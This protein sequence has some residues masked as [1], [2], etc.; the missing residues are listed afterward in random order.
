M[1]SLAGWCNLVSRFMTYQ[2]PWSTVGFLTFA[3]T[4]SRKKADGTQESFEDTIERCLTACDTQLGVGF[5]PEE[6]ED[7]KKLLMELK[8][9]FAGRFLWQLGVSTVDQLG[10]PSLQNCAG[11]VVDSPVRPFTWAM[12]M[13]M[14]GSGVGFS[15][16]KKY[17]KKLPK[18]KKNFESPTCINNANADFIVPDT[19]EGWVR[20]LGKTL[21]SAFLETKPKCTFTYSTQLV[22]GKGALIK[23][24]GGVASGPEILVEGISKIGKILESRRGQKVSAVDVMDIM[25]IIGE[26]V[27]AGS[28]RRSSEIALGDSDDI[29][30]LE[31]KRWDLKQIPSHRSSSNNSVVC[32]DT[33]SLP[34]T[35]WEGYKGNGECY[36]LINMEASRKYGRMGDTD[37]P[38]PDVVVYNPCV[39]GDTLVLTRQGSLPIVELVGKSID[40]WNGQNWSTVEPKV[41]GRNQPMLKVTLSDGRYL[42]C[43]RYHVWLTHEASQAESPV[44]RVRAEDLKVG[45]LVPAQH[46]PFPAPT[47]GYRICPETSILSIEEAGVE[48][49]VYCFSESELHQGTFNNIVTGQCSEQSLNNYET[50]ALAE[51]FLPNCKTQEE[52]EKSVFY[53][54]RVVKHS[55]RLPCHHPETQE[56]VHKNMRMG[57]GVTGYLQA[58]EEQRSWLPVTYLKLRALD[59]EYSEK[60]GFPESIKLTT[61]KPSGCRPKD[62]L[63]TTDVGIL[64]LE[65][66]AGTLGESELADSAWASVSSMPAPGAGTITKFFNNG[67][68]ETYTINM[69]YGMSVESTGNHPWWVEGKGWVKTEDIQEGDQLQVMPGL[70][71]NTKNTMLTPVTYMPRTNSVQAHPPVEVNEDLAW[72]VGYLW[73]NGSLSP[74]PKRLR[75]I[76]NHRN[77]LEKVQSILQSYGLSAAIK[78]ASG[79][80]LADSLEIGNT[81]LY[82]WFVANGFWK[83]REDGGPNP[84]PLKIRESSS[85]SIL[86]FMA[87][88]FDADGCWNKSSRGTLSNADAVFS[89][90]IQDVAWAVGLAYSRSHNTKGTN[91]QASKSIWLM[92]ISAHTT[93]DAWAVFKRNSV[94]IPHGAELNHNRKFKAGLVHSVVPS[95]V[96]PTFDVETSEHWFWAGAVKSHNTLSLLPGVT[97]GIHPGYARYMIRRIQFSADSP[98]IPLIKSHG[99]PVEY[100]QNFDG[101]L[102][103]RTLIASF[104]FSYPEGTVL[105]QDMTAIQQLD[106]VRRVQREWSDN[107]VS[108]TV[109]YRKEELPAIREYLEQH[110]HEMKAV[111]F[112]LHSDHGF[113]QAPFESITKEEYDDLVA[114]TRLITSFDGLA[115]DDGPDYSSECAGGSC[116]IR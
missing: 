51:V 111:S 100:R 99:Y 78:P 104:P 54:Y 95:G 3:R 7:F 97:P 102:D 36:G 31:A 80:R 110:W 96:K 30:Y 4:Y 2:T 57:I 12:D 61:T 81:H 98:L 106:V 86:A 87:G 20:L 47:R 76:S 64:T 105:A 10:L 52:F 113:K 33:K 46:T 16:E 38:D 21:K 55:L 26:I 14:L 107:A 73:G 65:E 116:P 75:F 43:T 29:H 92:N 77:T 103:Y 85:A 41:T 13:L 56:I 18:V 9:S 88:L 108:C 27:I 11:V 53:L 22:R 50:C 42:V 17:L 35:F 70:Y 44:V 115:S 5:T 34:E 112:L 79:D 45:D 8:C 25:N 93:C 114:K 63:V 109:Y 62:S 94:K 90:H 1:T 91:F 74:S 89:K 37:Y 68:A 15:V 23:G 32:S 101:S 60:Q 6:R 69:L 49:T 83:Y 67:L 82:D 39:K 58:T 24:F 71:R 84:I 66:I 28:V 72:L 59:K 48:E 19:R 40:V